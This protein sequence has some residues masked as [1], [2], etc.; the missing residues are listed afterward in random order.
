M[1]RNVLMLAWEYPPKV[2]GGLARHVGYLSRA[3][4][5]R[6]DRVVV[7]TQGDDTLPPTED[8]HGVEVIRLPVHDPKPRDFTGWVKRLN[9]EMIERAVHMFTSGHRFDIVHAHDWLAAYA[10]KTLKHGLALPLVATVHATE[11]GRN[12]GLHNDLQRYISTV[13]WSLT[14][15]AWRVICCSRFMEKEI[16]KVFQTPLDKIRIVPNGIDVPSLLSTS[17]T[18]RF[19]ADESFRRRFAAPD[20]DVI[21]FI[22]RLVFEKGVHVLLDALPHILRRRPGARVVIAGDGPLRAELERQAAR[23]GMADRVI[24]F[25]FADDEERDRL[26]RISQ[27]AVFP[28]LYEPFGIVAL[29]AMAAQVPVVVG[30]VGGF[31]EIV[32]HGENGL[33]APPG[34]ATALAD[35]IVMMLSNPS[36]AAH[37]RETALRDVEQN[38]TWPQIAA[39]TADIYNEVLKE[40]EMAR[41]DAAEN[42]RR[43]DQMAAFEA[44]QRILRHIPAGYDDMVSRYT[45]T[46]DKSAGT[47]AASARTDTA[48]AVSARATR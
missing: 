29:E 18:K 48:A 17:R 28:S 6:G 11:Y 36:L 12:N 10:G 14:Y 32:H 43:S 42:R 7:L 8:D 25:G 3:L 13:E 39:A 34:D 33:H 40:Y 26:L 46:G 4:V 47:A 1:S 20:E 23:L 44:L 41:W 9:F 38:Y 24:F 16:H 31:A 2:I 30:K 45:E 5:E 21:F 27:V 37:V 15:E 22:G 19:A 35:A